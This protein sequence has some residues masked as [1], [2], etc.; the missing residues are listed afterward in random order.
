MLYA[1]PYLLFGFLGNCDSASSSLVQTCSASVRGLHYF[2]NTEPRCQFNQLKR[3]QEKMVKEVRHYQFNWTNRTEMIER[4][5]HCRFNWTNRKE[6]VEKARERITHR[7][8][9]FLRFKVPVYY[10]NASLSWKQAANEFE[11]WVWVAATHEYMLF[12]PHNFNVLSL[13]TMGII[14]NDFWEPGGEGKIAGHCDRTCAE[15]TTKIPRCVLT[16]KDI[17]QF[18]SDVTGEKTEWNYVCL[19]LDYDIADVILNPNAALPDLFYYWRFLR[20]LFSRRPYFGIGMSNDDFI[21][22]DCFDRD[23]ILK[24]KELLMNYFVIL[25]TAILLWLYSPLLVHYFPSSE[26]YPTISYPAVLKPTEFHP[27]YKSPVRFGYFVRCLLCYYMEKSNNLNY[28]S[29]IRRTVFLCC[30]FGVSFRF[31]YTPYWSY[32]VFLLTCFLAM[33]LIPEFWSVHLSDEHPT[34]FL[35]LWEYPK[36]VFRNNLCVL[37]AGHDVCLLSGCRRNHVYLHRRSHGPVDGV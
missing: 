12:F 21:H 15:F 33:A 22:Y 19:Q 13:G 23:G 20:Q 3:V 11:T 2:A 31:L 28:K 32:Q 36:G 1:L 37:H 9:L 5:H 7:Q 25:I 27:T 10:P 29:R 8:K 34:H 6:M 16:W 26:P 35:D 14:T 24:T 30:L 18:M 4:V 17:Q